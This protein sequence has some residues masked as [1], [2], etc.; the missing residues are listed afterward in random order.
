MA[1]ADLRMQI[2]TALD[3]AGIKA[4][5]KEIDNL[6][7]KLDTLGKSNA[8]DKLEAK[9]TK[10]PSKLGEVVGSMGKFGKALGVAGA[11]VEA[12]KQGWEIGSWINEKF[13][14]PILWAG[15]KA[16]EV[17]EKKIAKA[18]DTAW[19]TM[20]KSNDNA[21]KGLQ[22]TG[23][24]EDQEV[25]RVKELTQQYLKA[26]SA[27]NT[28]ANASMDADMQK[29]EIEQF[30]DEMSLIEQGREDAIP[31]LQAY[32]DMLKQEMKMK[33]ELADF[34]AKTEEDRIKN[35]TELNNKLLEYDTKLNQRKEKIA[36]L[37]KQR[38]DAEEAFFNGQGRTSNK[39][40]QKWLARDEKLKDKQ[41]ELQ[42]E[43]EMIELEKKNFLAGDVFDVGQYNQ[44]R[45]TQRA[46]L[47]GRL[48]LEA[49]KLGFNYNSLVTGQ[50]TNL[51]GFGPEYFQEKMTQDAQQSFKDLSDIERNTANLAEKLDQLL[52]LK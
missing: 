19:K 48:S 4:S 49:Q 5:Q 6:A 18:W 15:D 35:Q 52:G 28:M 37:E 14:D 32:Y 31:E 2:V 50:G 33:K 39:K 26:Y 7:S 20:E 29:L 30:Q 34:D 3:S 25:Q 40:K 27:K 51:L 36:L 16:E 8:T 22:Q 10:L 9:L 47:A 13:V 43:I 23:K 41:Q 21:I 38:D 45:A 44:I 11:I 42:D 1:N 46:T 12:F 17:A 24:L